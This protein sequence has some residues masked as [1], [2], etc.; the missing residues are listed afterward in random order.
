MIHVCVCPPPHP[1]LVA[2]AVLWTTAVCGSVMGD[3]FT[4]DSNYAEQKGLFMWYIV[5]LVVR[6]QSTKA[7]RSFDGVMVCGGGGGGAATRGHVQPPKL[8]PPFTLPHPI[9]PHPTPILC[10]PG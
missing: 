2:W 5:V 6:A 1:T 7:R 8:Q 4:A 10:A 9:P 3:V